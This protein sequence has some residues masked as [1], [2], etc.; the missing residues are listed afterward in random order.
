MKENE[1]DGAANHIIT[2]LGLMEKAGILLLGGVE[3]GC[4]DG[5]IR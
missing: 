4:S 3:A 2:A 5:H 1:H